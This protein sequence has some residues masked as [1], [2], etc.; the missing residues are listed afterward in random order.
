MAHPNE[1]LVRSVYD[2]F[3]KGDMDTIT[4]VLADDIVW[5]S[6]GKHHFAGDYKGKDAVLGLFGTLMQ[7]TGGTFQ[8]ELHDLLAND[9]HAVALQTNRAERKG[10]R[11][12]YRDVLIFHVSGGRVT[13]AWPFLENP[14]E[15]AA[16]YA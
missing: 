2:A 7:E 10:R 5:H 3:A 1:E 9:T 13:E 8:V 16:F 12:E 14:D 6:L 11:I 4:R 15:H